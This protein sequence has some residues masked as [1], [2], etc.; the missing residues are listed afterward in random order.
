MSALSRRDTLR[1]SLGL[2]VSSLA[3]GAPMRSFA[4]G[5]LL[6]VTHYGGPYVALETII[7]EPFMD[8]GLG[9]VEYEQDQP[10]LILAKWQAQPDSP[11]YDIGLFERAPTLRAGSSGLALPLTEQNVPNI[12]NALPGAV[13]EGGAGVALAFDTID[14][15]Y[16]TDQVSEP[17]TSWLDLWRPELA[18]KIML[19]GLPIDG[20]VAF[21][22]VAVARAMGMTEEQVDEVFPRFIELKDSVH[23]FYSDPNQASQLIE[24]G[25]IAV[26]I[27]Y[28]AR[29]GQL[30]K[31]Y[32]NIT[33]ATPT[34][35]VPAIP[36]DLV[37][38]AN[39]SAPETAAE[40]VNFALQP[41]IQAQVCSTILL[42]P[43]V[44]GVDV[45]EE[46]LSYIITDQSKMFPVND[47]VVLE[48]QQGWL[49]RWQ[50]EVQS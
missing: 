25:E 50:R 12:V 43:A 32:P 33:R 40:Y 20:A 22:L 34:E 10:N 23:S 15:M 18:G 1:L 39:T 3:L 30:M 24:R 36:Y 19:P 7:G 37:V 49:E 48:L 31:R 4:A 13:A 47:P 41:D 29:I 35:G 26:A 45:G 28:S 27:Q 38:A 14:I 6:R 16:D 44:S 2:G 5:D 42:N 9:E 8:A 46:T 21:T 17:I 11:V